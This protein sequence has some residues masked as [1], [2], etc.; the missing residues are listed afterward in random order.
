MDENQDLVSGDLTPPPLLIPVIHTIGSTVGSNTQ[1]RGPSESL[2]LLVH[3]GQTGHQE[4][5]FLSPKN[6][7]ENTASK[8]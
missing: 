8:L 4:D 6:V 2:G 3:Q 7:S 1:S 5:G